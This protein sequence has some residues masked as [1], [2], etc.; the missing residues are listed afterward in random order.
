MVP[1]DAMDERPVIRL[2][3]LE[4]PPYTSEHLP[5]GGLSTSLLRKAIENAGFRLEVRFRPWRRALAEAE[6]DSDVHGYFP[7]YYS[8]AI[9][10]QF[11]FSIPIGHSPVG[12]AHRRDAMFDWNSI[13]DLVSYRFGV[14]DGYVNSGPFDRAWEVGELA[15][16]TTVSDSM[17]LRRLVAGRIDAAVIDP[18]VMSYIIATENPQWRR[19]LRFHPRPLNHH[20]LYVAFRQGALPDDM[21]QAINHAIADLDIETAMARYLEAI[22]DTLSAGYLAEDAHMP[23]LP[24]AA[25]GPASQ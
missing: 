24:L 8:L 19:P 18:L 12:F 9:T 3:T 13:A 7:E 10:E 4:W 21:V 15:V 16:E 11:E 1:T 17:N 14:V 20:R 23:L 2:T 5:D 22:S 6:R 25:P